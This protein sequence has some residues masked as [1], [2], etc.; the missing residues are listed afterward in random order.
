MSISGDEAH[1]VGA[2]HE[3]RTVEEEPRV[4]TGDRKLRLRDHLAEASRGN[5]AR[6]APAA[7]GSV[8]KSSRGS[9]CIRESNRSAATFTPFLS[10]SIR[11]SVSGSA[12]TIS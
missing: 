9:V 4:F 6:A 8:G 3:Q 10:S 11:T 7:S 1:R 5:V 12:L 2:Q